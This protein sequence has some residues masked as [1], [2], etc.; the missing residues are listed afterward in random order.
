MKVKLELCITN[1]NFNT[2]VVQQYRTI[3]P[4]ILGMFRNK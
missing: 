1:H 4:I 3:R 2:N